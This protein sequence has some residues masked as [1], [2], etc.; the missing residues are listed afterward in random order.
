MAEIF[1]TGLMKQV[2]NILIIDDDAVTALLHKRL[3]E[4]MR[5]AQKIEFIN[6]PFHALDYLRQL[7]A[8]NTYT[9]SCPDLIFLDINMP[10]MNGFEFIEALETQGID[11]R[12]LSIVMYTSSVSVKDRQQALALKDKILR[13]MVKPLQKAEV[14][15]LV[16]ELV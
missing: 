15:E 8:T 7:Y 3:L 16:E 5:I 2:C 11:C 10:G 14:E 1:Y 13:Y 4:S 6:D 12:R 9:G